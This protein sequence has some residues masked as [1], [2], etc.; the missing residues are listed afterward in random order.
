[1]CFL[2]TKQFW[3]RGNELLA[4]PLHAKN[5]LNLNLSFPEFLSSSGTF[6]FCFT[7][8]FKFFL[9]L[10]RACLGFENIF[11]QRWFF[12]YKSV[13]V[14]RKY[15]VNV[16]LIQ[17]RRWSLLWGVI[18]GQGKKYDFLKLSQENLKVVFYSVLFPLSRTAHVSH[19]IQ[20]C[21]ELSEP[22]LVKRDFSCGTWVVAQLVKHLTLD[23]SS[24]HGI[25]PQTRLC[26]Q[27]GV[28][29]RVSPPPPT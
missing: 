16:C 15:S 24:G 21:T 4:F 18:S 22:L 7:N 1:M 8:G 11:I 12:D 27:H 10:G 20:T 5:N 6:K 9:R 14:H 13:R 25:Q 2:E 29:L 3:L 17:L 26:T 23:F 19:R 28:C